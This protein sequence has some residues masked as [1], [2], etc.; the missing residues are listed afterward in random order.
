[1][2]QIDT[3]A[4]VRL[5][6]VIGGDEDDLAEFIQDFSEEAPDLVSQMIAGASAGDWPALKIAT[7]SL[8]SNCKDFGALELGELCQVLES[9]SA[10]GEVVDAQQKVE[11]ISIQVKAAVEA[12]QAL[13]LTTI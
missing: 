10:Q 9:E 4:L 7:H 3:S 1:M 6:D 12:L 5:R 2:M 13:D 8:K 11:K